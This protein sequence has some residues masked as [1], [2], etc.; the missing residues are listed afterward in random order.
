VAIKTYYYKVNGDAAVRLPPLLLAGASPIV[1]VPSTD[2]P[3]LAVTLDEIHKTDLDDAMADLGF[4][5]VAETV[6]KER[7]IAFPDSPYTPG[8]ELV[9]L[10]DAT[11]GP[12]IIDLPALATYAV[13]IRQLK[14]VKTDGTGNTVTLDPFGGELIN[15]VGSFSLT[16]Q[17]DS[18][19]IISGPTQW[20]LLVSPSA[21]SPPPN[22]SVTAGEALV[23]GDIVAYDN[24]SPSEVVL[25]DR[26]PSLSPT[27]YDAKGIATAAAAAGAATTIYSIPG[28]RVPVRFTAAPA[29]A[30]NG[31]RVYLS[32]TAG[33][34]TLVAPGSTAALVQVGILVGADGA[35]TTP[36][37][38]FEFNVIAIVS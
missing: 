26:D 16:S 10:A 29:A 4:E 32:A 11:A 6:G 2:N 37:V 25:A 19:E 27:K 13:S 9:I 8:Q 24:S 1:S 23:A 33:Q 5:F 20:H 36:D 28:Q 17:Y 18:A 34:A 12:I 35:T 14:V 15:G 7:S 38:V 3:F 30:D 22:L 31:K 21:P